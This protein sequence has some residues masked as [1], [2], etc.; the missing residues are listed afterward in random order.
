MFEEMTA[1]LA[2]KIEL[3]VN[4]HGSEK[5]A[6]MYW[7]IGETSLYGKSK[8]LMK[9]LQQCTV[10]GSDANVQS[11]VLV[12][13]EVVLEFL[14][15]TKFRERIFDVDDTSPMY[16][17]LNTRF[18]ED[19]RIEG[20]P[21]VYAYASYDSVQILGLAIEATGDAGFEDVKR[22]IPMITS[23]YSGAIG[24]ISLNA[25]GDAAEAS[26]AIWIIAESGWERYG[27]Y[28]PG[29]GFVPAPVP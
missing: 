15:N 25:A 1:T 22:Q 28:V 3:L 13:N 18:S 8:P 9:I 2:D 5:I 11:E 20:N 7:G 14:K 27:T 29:T 21:N 24:N 4:E 10:I 16:T 26:Y 19:P 12:N 23:Q 17:E 6:V